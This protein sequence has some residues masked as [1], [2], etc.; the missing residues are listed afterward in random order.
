MRGQS[1]VALPTTLLAT[2]L[3]SSLAAA[4]LAVAGMEPHIAVNLRDETRARHLADAGVDWALD[5]LTGTA[6]W[7]PL[8]T[9]ATLIGPTPLPGLAA[10]AGTVTVTIRNDDRPG[11]D[12][13]TGVAVDPGGAAHDTNGVV[14]VTAAGAVNGVTR[15]VEAVLRRG[16]D[17]ADTTSPRGASITHWKE[18]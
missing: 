16:G 4:F 15:Q 6:D 9:A 8:L 2:L 18:M 17:P 1:G 14:V 13:I 5:R 11:D 3:I 7:S 10:A 12:R